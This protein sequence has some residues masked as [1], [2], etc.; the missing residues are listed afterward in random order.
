L[1]C[2]S[3]HLWRMAAPRVLTDKPVGI[4]RGVVAV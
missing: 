1:R 3:P 4:S 2:G